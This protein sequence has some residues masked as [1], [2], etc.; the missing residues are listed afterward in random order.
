MSQINCSNN[1]DAGMDGGSAR[2]NNANESRKEKIQ[3]FWQKKH[4]ARSLSKKVRYR[5]RQNLAQ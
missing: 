2:N 1:S 4:Q 5:C 3:R